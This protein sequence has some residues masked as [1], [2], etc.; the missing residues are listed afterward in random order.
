MTAEGRVKDGVYRANLSFIIHNPLSIIHH[1]SSIIRHPSSTIHHIGEYNANACAI[2][3]N[4][5]TNNR[6]FDSQN[7]AKGGYEV[8]DDCKPSK[9]GD[10]S[11]QGRPCNF[12]SGNPTNP[13]AAPDRLG[14]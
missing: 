10:Q 11:Y 2:Q 6:L 4:R 8:G 5:Q 7:N 14:G 3:T 1:P 13:N 12:N 9:L